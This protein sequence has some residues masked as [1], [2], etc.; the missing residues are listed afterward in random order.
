[1][2]LARRTE[3]PILRWSL[4]VAIL[5]AEIL[6]L[7]I[8]FDAGVMAVDSG[9]PALV[10]Y[11]SPY[12]LRSGL[13]AAIVVA[14]LSLWR[15]NIE[16]RAAAS[17]S[18]ARAA[19][20]WLLLQ[21]AA[22]GLFAL[23]TQSVFERPGRGETIRLWDLGAWAITGFLTF[24]LWAAAVISPCFWP[25]L[26]RRGRGVFAIGL[27]V[28][29]V[30]FV[31]AAAVQRGW[32]FL[33][34][35]TLLTAQWLLRFVAGDVV[36]D[37]EQR[38]LGTDNFRVTV[39]AQCSGYEGIGLILA[40][41]LAYF[42]IFRRDLR[43]PH[44][45]VMVPIGVGAIWLTNAARIA[46]LIWI[47]SRVSPE[48]ALGGFHSQ[49]GWLGFATVSILLIIAGHRCRFFTTRTRDASAPLVSPTLAYLAPFLF[50][51]TILIVA[52]A[53]LSE[54]ATIHPVRTVGVGI[55]LM[56]LWAHYEWTNDAPRHHARHVSE[57]VAIGGA[58]FVGWVALTRLGLAGG[59]SLEVAPIPN[60]L[61]P[62]TRLFWIWAWVIGYCVVTPFAEELAFRGYLL[63][64]LVDFDFRSVSPHR[65]TWLSFLISSIA[66]GLLHKEWV[67]GSLAGM[68][69]AGVVYRSGQLRSAVIAHSVTNLLIAA[70]LLTATPCDSSC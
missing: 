52:E 2:H 26:A 60:G 34:G 11:R 3:L 39:S 27:V 28:T 22:F 70:R 54:P 35:P 21:L 6:A 14:V 64:R 16:I 66:F 50:S 4:L 10:L 43:F 36:C 53:F 62:G 51:I 55:L 17:R 33:S 59:E 32:D 49:A 47:G 58:V 37:P 68:A 30:A 13:V 18:S 44:A 46:A 23:T 9:W 29:G 1:M 5:L 31:A 42:W 25:S 67:A 12:L 69:Y 57:A 65:F 45:L 15:L 8:G 41:L 63:R 38:L 61:T 48:L 7:S 20:L 19:C 40:M 56:L 24:A